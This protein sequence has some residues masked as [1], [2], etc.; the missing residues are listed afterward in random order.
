ML[1]ALN[2]WCDPANDVERLAVGA[3]DR[4]MLRE[5]EIANQRFVTVHQTRYTRPT[6]AFMLAIT[7]CWQ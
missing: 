1:R 6:S 7:L 3:R 4:I 5:T 2:R